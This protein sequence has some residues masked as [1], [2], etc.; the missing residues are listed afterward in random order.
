[1]SPKEKAT[2]MLKCNREA[3]VA[4][5]VQAVIEL[6]NRKPTEASQEFLEEVMRQRPD[7]LKVQ[8]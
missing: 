2:I 4:V 1:M 6:H 5:V 3:I 7:M 8:G